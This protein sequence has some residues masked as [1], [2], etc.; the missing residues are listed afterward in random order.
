MEMEY[1]K[2]GEELRRMYFFLFPFEKKKYFIELHLS[3]SIR[4]ETQTEES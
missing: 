2:E 3:F 4:E 1:K